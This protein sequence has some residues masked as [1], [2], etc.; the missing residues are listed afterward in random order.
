MRDVYKS[1]R[2]EET[3]DFYPAYAYRGTPRGVVVEGRNG[4]P[5]KERRPGLV[6]GHGDWL[7][8]GRNHQNEVKKLTEIFADRFRQHLD[9]RQIQAALGLTRQVKRAVHIDLLPLVFDKMEKHTSVE[10]FSKEKTAYLADIFLALVAEGQQ[11]ATQITAETEGEIYFEYEISHGEE[12]T[13]R[14]FVFSTPKRPENLSIVLLFSDD[15][16]GIELLDCYSQANRQK[17]VF[18]DPEELFASLYYPLQNFPDLTTVAAVNFP[19]I[20]KDLEILFRQIERAKERGP[21]QKELQ[22]YASNHLPAMLKY[23]AFMDRAI[24]EEVERQKKSG[25]KGK[26]AAREKNMGKKA[27]KTRHGGRGD[28]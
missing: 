6:P 1:R 16:A 17:D 3:K 23:Y 13:G 14:L 7:R 5:R 20:W 2:S 10:Q 27:R 28:R 19:E 11:N 25:K 12:K 18:A 4:K 22:K 24:G 15:S 21:A 9:L 26:T 8:K